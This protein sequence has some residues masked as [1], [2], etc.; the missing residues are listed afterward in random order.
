MERSVRENIKF[1]LN[2]IIILIIIIMISR[3]YNSDECVKSLAVII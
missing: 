2:S 3:N 1:A